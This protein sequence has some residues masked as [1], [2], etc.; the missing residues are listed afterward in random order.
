MKTKII[1]WGIWLVLF[2]IIVV[3]FA[4]RPTELEQTQKIY[5]KIINEIEWKNKD[6][7]NIKNK[8]L[9]DK[10]QIDII[11]E[12]KKILEKEKECL[13]KNLENIIKWEEKQPC[14]EITLKKKT[15]VLKK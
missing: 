8:M 11:W 13:E 12:E 7:E 14:E 2:V 3:F 1:W 5:N 4:T 6:Y 10:K 15:I 9:E